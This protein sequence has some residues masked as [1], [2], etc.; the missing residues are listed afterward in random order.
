VFSPGAVTSSTEVVKWVWCV[1]RVCVCRLESSTWCLLLAGVRRG[2]CVGRA[3]AVFRPVCLIRG[4][5]YMWRCSGVWDI[6]RRYP[7]VSHAIDI[8]CVC[9]N[10]GGLRGR[11]GDTGVGIGLVYDGQED[12]FIPLPFP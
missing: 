1:A 9:C 4:V 2:M 12:V 8:W 10:E 11:E 7:C 6:R 3:S 5:V